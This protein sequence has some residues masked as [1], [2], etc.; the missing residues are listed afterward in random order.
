MDLGAANTQAFTQWQPFEDG[1]ITHTVFRAGQGPG[2]LLMHELPGMTPEFWRLANWLATRFT[3]FAPDLF[4]KNAPHTRLGTARLFAKAC[5]SREIHLFSRNDPGPI[6]QWLRALARNLHDETG[7]PGVGVI[8]M[9][10]TGNFALTLALDPWVTAPVASQ[11]GIPI[12]LPLRPRHGDLQMNEDDRR[13][14]AQRDVDVMG[15]RF[16]GD[17]YCRAA[18][19][20]TIREVIGAERFKDHVLEDRHQNPARQGENPHS[21]LTADLVDADDSVTKQKLIEVITFIEAR[22][23]P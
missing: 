23:A 9:C 18:R 20:D 4:G 10:M 16:E 15:L 3:V 21:V 13:D 12:S 7:G 8:G 6:T 22:I 17:D 19:F 1:G 11:P 2:V 5:I 14:L